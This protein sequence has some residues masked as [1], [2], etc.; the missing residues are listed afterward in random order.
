[1]SSPTRPELVGNFGMVATTHWLA[2]A[3]GMGILEAGGNAADA[4]VAAGF[5]LQVVEPHLCGPG[6]EVPILV[7]S[8]SEQRVSAICGQGVSPAAAT[9]DRVSA[10]GLDI[11]P[12]TGLIPAVVPGAFGAWMLL[13]ERQ[14]T[15]TPEQVLA[16]AIH[17][18]EKGHP[19]LK[20]ASET[21][22]TVEELFAEHW[23]TSAA[24]WLREGRAP[25]PGSRIVNPALAGVYRRIVA[26]SQS[27]RGSRE[28]QIRAAVDA[29]Y[30]GFVAEAISAFCETTE[31]MDSS[32][33]R[34]GAL[35]RADDLAR[36]DATV[37]EPLSFRYHDY[38]VFKTGPWGQG[39]VFLQQLALLAGYDLGEAGAGSADWIHLILESSK[40]AFADRE[41]W[42]GDPVHTDVPMADLL[43]P[44]Y[45]DERRRLIGSSAS[46]ELRPGDPG[47]RPAR[48]PDYPR[49]D[50][51]PLPTGGIGEPT[52]AKTG[53]TRGD[54]CHVDVVDADGM[55][56]S[57]TP[58]G[59]WLQ[60]SPTIPQLGF[61]LS[62][63]GQM[64]WVQEGLPNSL[65]PS[66]RPRTTLSPSFAL[67]NGQ[68]WL[69][70][71]TPGGDSQDQWQVQFFLNVVHGGLNL[72]EA[73]DAPAFHSTHVPSSFYPRQSNPGE[74][75]VEARFDRSVL[76]ELRRRGHRVVVGDGWSE[77]RL[78][79]VARDSGWL[80]AGA[81]PR[82]SQGYAVG[83]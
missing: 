46:L 55:M 75:V 65:R 24:V 76:D 19:F 26:E 64:F 1:M 17:Y 4:A 71:G 7:W 79:A 25:A 58:S 63:R 69:A 80:K 44:A 35:L 50:R 21:V 16:P 8:E 13:L 73:I 47:G 27:A 68:P 53:E 2:S 62:N 57:A 74:V 77:G 34:H 70:F 41:A 5:V 82:G 39:P 18:A 12:G 66:A 43:S 40:L 45:N 52:V 67:R 78:S 32:G 10:L 49:S 11:M 31:V 28:N 56:V 30:R 29:W 14:G 36:W 48:L 42:Y 3:T 22:R 38:E 59:G 23:P 6:G 9:I 83:R 81:N 51:I 20:K 60:S 72:Q 61:C 33:E 54:T 37:E 15:M